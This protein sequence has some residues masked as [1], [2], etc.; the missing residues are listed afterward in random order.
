MG[1]D[2]VLLI[3]GLVLIGVAADQAVVGAARLADRF[4]LPR[5]VVGALLI[6]VGTSMPELFVDTLAVLE[7]RPT[8][9]LGELMGSNAANIGLVLG[10]AALVM[11]R[12]LVVDSG[13]LAR[14]VPLS[15][16]AC[17]VFVVVVLAGSPRLA[18]LALLV[19]AVVVV[20]TIVTR[21]RTAPV[22]EPGDVELSREVGVLVGRVSV[23]R[24]WVRAL[25]GLAVT[26]VAAQ[27]VLTGAVSLAERFGLAEGFVGLA[28]IAVGT[29]LPELVTAL[30]G[31]RRGEDEL[32]IGNVLGSN[33]TNSLLVGG[34]VVLLAGEPAATPTLRA[35]GLLVT[36]LVLLLA[37]AMGRGLHVSRVE[38]ALLLLTWGAGLALVATV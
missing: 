27:G 14:E 38:G 13:V 24:E 21:P 29:S 10:S 6:G 36:S 1:T 20:R 12:P 37:M 35:A 28:I 3:G 5:V 23:P 34:I 11:A 33:L 32:V 16:G 31:V 25:A 8:L 2:I 9:A 22:T 19:G 26:L 15:L 18:G 4:R 30:T 7:G 17:L